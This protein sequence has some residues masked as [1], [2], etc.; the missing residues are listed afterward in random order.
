M[1]KLKSYIRYLMH[2]SKVF[3]II[4]PFS[5]D[6]NTYT[7]QTSTWETFNIREKLGLFGLHSYGKIDKVETFHVLGPR[8]LWLK[9]WSSCATLNIIQGDILCV[10]EQK[11][12]CKG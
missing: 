4:R 1:S 12:V 9:T 11:T 7:K 5:L 8:H 2:S 10:M 3:T 6:N